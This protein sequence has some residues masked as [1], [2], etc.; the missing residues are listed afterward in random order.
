ML[1]PDAL[2]KA[3]Q[4]PKPT[5]LRSP[6]H[7]EEWIHAC[8]GGGAAGSNFDWAGPLTETVLMG[9]VALRLEMRE[10][11]DRQILKW[12]AERHA[13]SN[14]PEANTYLHKEYREGWTL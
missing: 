5:V 8:K 11:L 9:N 3:Y 14:C 7:Y 6:G 13:F 10:Q 1:L 4:R 2:R 12:D